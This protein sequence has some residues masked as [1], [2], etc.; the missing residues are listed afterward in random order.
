[1]VAVSF[2]ILDITS[3]GE[4]KPLNHQKISMNSKSLISRNHL[5]IFEMYNLFKIC[6]FL[7]MSNFRNNK[8]NNKIN[9]NVKFP[10]DVQ[11]SKVTIIEVFQFKKILN[12]SNT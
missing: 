7:K 3:I 1:M 10:K 5:N 2:H 11:F 12:L 8:T 4:I 6:D 9:W